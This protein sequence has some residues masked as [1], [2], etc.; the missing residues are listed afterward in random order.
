MDLYKA[1]SGDTIEAA[2]REFVCAC[3]G[4]GGASRIP[5]AIRELS[6]D[7]QHAVIKWTPY[8]LI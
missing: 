1:Q 5:L 8:I 7:K 6:H 2:V 3:Q 4:G